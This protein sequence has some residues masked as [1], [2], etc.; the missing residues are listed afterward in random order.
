M[1]TFVW[2]TSHGVNPIELAYAC[3]TENAHN[4]C[5]AIKTNNQ[6]KTVTQ[7][8]TQFMIIVNIMFFF[9]F[10]FYSFVEW[11]KVKEEW[12]NLLHC[13][14][15]SR[16]LWIVHIYG[17]DLLQY[18]IFMFIQTNYYRL[19]GS[20]IVPSHSI[21]QFLPFNKVCVRVIFLFFSTI[22]IEMIFISIWFLSH[23]FTPA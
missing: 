3:W 23:S 17:L 22:Q 20:F 5:L 12:R 6:I 19:F 8:T 11:S 15:H 2:R 14:S 21:L 7:M 16:I 13:L 1:F 18:N 4:L 9:L 10:F